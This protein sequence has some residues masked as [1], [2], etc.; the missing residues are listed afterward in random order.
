MKALVAVLPLLLV[1]VQAGK[2]LHHELLD[3]HS[4]GSHG[5]SLEGHGGGI[6]LG[7]HKGLDA[8]ELGGH[9]GGLAL[10]GYKGLDAIELGGHNY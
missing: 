3:A 10:E 5:I 4:L 9:G 6:G 1:A 8:I 2:L 7:G